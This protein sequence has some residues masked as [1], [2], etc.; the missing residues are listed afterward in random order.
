MPTTFLEVYTELLDWAGRSV[1]EPG[2]LTRAKACVNDAILYANRSHKF[3]M[4]ERMS[5][6]TY[7][8]NASFVDLG[9]VCDGGTV[10]GVSTVQLISSPEQRIGKTIP[11]MNYAELQ[12]RRYES[13]NKVGSYQIEAAVNQQ[14]TYFDSMIT[15]T[16][17][18]IAF[19][20]GDKFGLYPTPAQERYILLTYNAL[21][22]PLVNDLD[23]NFFLTFCKDWVIS[24]SLQR[25]NM[26][27][28]DDQRIPIS[29]AQIKDDWNSLI[30]WDDEMLTNSMVA[31]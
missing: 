19:L 17:N 20:Q 21:F 27:L 23:T 29:D 15:S 1:Q 3:R 8:T 30:R 18:H 4:A 28:K 13:Q 7:P 10:S 22:P 25:F 14:T 16:Y 2:M 5:I 12:N 6:I 11:L 31:Y 9:L 24:K 26:Y